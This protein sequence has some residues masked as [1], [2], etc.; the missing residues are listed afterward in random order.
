MFLILNYLMGIPTL[1]LVGFLT[2]YHYYLV[3]TN[4]TSVESWE[5]DRVGRQI[6]RGLIPYTAFPFDVGCWPNVTAVMGPH[7]WRWAW[8]RGSPGNGLVFAVVG[9]HDSQYAWPPAD[10]RARRSRPRRLAPDDAAAFTY[11]D[12]Q[13][14]PALQPSHQRLPQPQATAQLRQRPPLAPAQPAPGDDGMYDSYSSDGDSVSDPDDYITGRGRVR[15]GSEGYEVRPPDY[16]RALWVDGGAAAFP[17]GTAPPPDA[18]SDGHAARALHD[19]NGAVA[20]ATK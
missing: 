8:R 19:T 16:R 2:L 3:C 13:L 12:G 9:D 20:E 14:N 10:P 1:A 6:R 7:P 5:K 17:P 4:T 18:S 15:R 11:G